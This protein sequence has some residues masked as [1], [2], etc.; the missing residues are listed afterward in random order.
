MGDVVPNPLPPGLSAVDVGSPLDQDTTK[1]WDPVV[2]AFVNRVQVDLTDSILAEAG[3]STLSNQNKTAIRNAIAKY[4]LPAG[5]PRV[6]F[7]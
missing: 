6:S 4:W 3:V 1:K 7:Q 2:H 5:N